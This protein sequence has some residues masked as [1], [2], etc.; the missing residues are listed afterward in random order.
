MIERD[1]GSY[2]NFLAFVESFAITVAK[3]RLLQKID[4]IEKLNGSTYTAKCG[5][6]RT[7]DCKLHDSEAC[8]QKWC[9]TNNISNA[10]NPVG[11]TIMLTLGP[12]YEAWHEGYATIYVFDVTT[13]LPQWFIYWLKRSKV[14]VLLWKY[15]GKPEGED[16]TLRLNIQGHYGKFVSIPRSTWGFRYL[17]VNSQTYSTSHFRD[18]SAHTRTY[19]YCT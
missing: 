3:S 13:L 11:W 5:E 17:M 12:T 4:C 19:T 18:N 7:V 10:P 16:L 8:G 6:P 1:V 2:Q 9:I 14:E 15:A